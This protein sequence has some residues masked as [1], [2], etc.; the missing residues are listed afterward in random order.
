MSSALGAREALLL[1]KE[2]PEIV[3]PALLQ[4]SASRRAIQKK[5][6]KLVK[7]GKVTVMKNVMKLVKEGK[8]TVKKKN[9]RPVRPSFFK[10]TFSSPAIETRVMDDPHDDTLSDFGL[11]AEHFYDG[12]KKVEIFK[13]RKSAVDSAWQFVEQCIGSDSDVD[14]V[15]FRK[16]LAECG[17]WSHECDEGEDL[18]V[19]VGTQAVK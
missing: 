6:M 10:L 16:E 8:V 11:L 9:V 7:K 14:E 4:D 12:E 3:I 13:T 15:S 1:L 2:R 19:E 5:V 18:V 17:I